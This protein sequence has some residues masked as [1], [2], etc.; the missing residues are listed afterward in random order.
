MAA[1]DATPRTDR[2]EAAG[3]DDHPRRRERRSPRWSYRSSLLLI[4]ALAS[5][6]RVG[7]CFV[8]AEDPPAGDALR[9]SMVGSSIAN[10]DGF[11]DP[12][13]GTPA[14]DHPP[15]AFLVESLSP[16]I[17]RTDV[18]FAGL[19]LWLFGQRLTMAAVGVGTVAVV[20]AVTRRI[21]GDSAALAAA[22]VAAVNPN[23]WVNDGLLMAESLAA[24]ATALFLWAIYRAL[25]S[26]S[27][28]AWAVAGAVGGLGALVRSESLLAVVL[29]VV[30]LVVWRCWGRWRAV[31]T[32]LLASGMSVALVCSLWIVPNLIRY[33]EPVL[34]STN[35]GLTLLGANC[36]D[37]YSGDLVGLWSLSCIRLADANGNGVDDWADFQ[38]ADPT[39]RSEF[40]PSAQSAVY[41]RTAADFV[42]DN[43]GATPR[44][45]SVRVARLWGLYRPSQ[46][47]AYNEGEGR[48]PT[49]SWLAW[50]W[51]LMSLPMVGWGLVSLRRRDIAVWPMLAQAVSATMVA[52]AVYGL[53]RFRIGWD[54][55]ATVALGVALVNRPRSWS[56]FLG[57]NRVERSMSAPPDAT[58]SAETN[59]ASSPGGTTDREDR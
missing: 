24:F 54:V 51:S 18:E 37:T 46:M 7:Y 31:G 20:A 44:V 17:V 57:P 22:A 1:I 49:L 9:Y 25:A 21:A 43:R 33:P 36:P 11:S 6:L 59:S 3:A 19:P 34:F 45:M 10:G 56:A 23:L 14:G 12:F 29:T 38:Q 42:A 39:R 15:V 16:A 48:R 58:S 27:V 8:I 55:A 13:S 40:E 30:P 32:K 47:V 52:A 5:L 50:A 2:P 41:R 53:V 4:V 35:D 28:S 26:S